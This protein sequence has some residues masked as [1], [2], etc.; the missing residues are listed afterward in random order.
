MLAGGFVHDYW[1]KRPSNEFPAR[2]KKTSRA[3]VRTRS[4]ELRIA[5]ETHSPEAALLWQGG[6]KRA[7]AAKA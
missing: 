1:R 7:G 2:R 6:G 3:T 5:V 4:G